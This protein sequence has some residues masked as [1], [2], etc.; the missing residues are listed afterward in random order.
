MKN[1]KHVRISI[2]GIKIYQ[3]CGNCTDVELTPRHVFDYPTIAA[4]MHCLDHT[5]DDDLYS[6]LA[7]SI[8]KIAMKHHDIW[9][10]LFCILPHLSYFFFDSSWVYDNTNNTRILVSMPLYGDTILK[11]LQKAFCH[12]RIMDFFIHELCFFFF[13]F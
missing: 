7:I 8:V 12:L 9:T 6:D 1:H 10:Q 3:K 13:F 11:R 5:L 2:D 4:T